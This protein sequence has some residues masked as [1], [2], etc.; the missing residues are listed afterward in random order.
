[1][2]IT[3]VLVNMFTSVLSSTPSDSQGLTALAA[4]ILGTMILVFVA[5][6]LYVVVLVKMRRGMRRTGSDMERQSLDLDPI[7]LVIHVLL[8][9]IFLFT[10]SIVSVSK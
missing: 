7:F 1:M 5:L 2:I 9:I 8:F 6:L 4:W 10:Y 3:Q